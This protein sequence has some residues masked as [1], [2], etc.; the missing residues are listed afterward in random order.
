MTDTTMSMAK[1]KRQRQKDKQ[2]FTKNY[3]QI[4]IR[5]SKTN[6]T[7]TDEPGYSG[8]VSSSCS[9]LKFRLKRCSRFVFIAIDFARSNVIFMQFAFIEILLVY[10]INFHIRWWSCRLIKTRWSHTWSRNYLP[11]RSIRVHLF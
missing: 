8:R 7:R 11:F 1:K 2:W 5:L 10:N 6:F 4:K 9:T 3:R